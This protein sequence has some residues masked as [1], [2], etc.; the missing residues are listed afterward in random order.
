[1]SNIE[2]PHNPEFTI[3]TKEKVVLIS[4][5][6]DTFEFHRTEDE[7]Y[8]SLEELKELLRTLDIQYHDHIFVQ[9]K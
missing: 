5:V 7:T 1:M 6:C 3:S 4:V 8:R 2:Q 9:K